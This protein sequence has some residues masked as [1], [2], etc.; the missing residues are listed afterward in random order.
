M[1]DNKKKIDITFVIQGKEFTIEVNIN[2]SIKAGV[3]KALEQASQSGS[4]K[5]WELR[6][7]SGELI[8]LDSSWKDQNI[9]SPT[10]LFL[11][12]GAGRG[13]IFNGKKT[14]QDQYTH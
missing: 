7:E 3:H 11:S 5:E 2:Q 6:T 1:N 4:H 10:K 14:Y 12:K 8:N 13:G 9:T